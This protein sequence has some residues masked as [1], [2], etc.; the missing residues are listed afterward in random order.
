MVDSI[1]SNHNNGIDEL[2]TGQ[3]HQQQQIERV[4][5][6]SSAAQNSGSTGAILDRADISDEALTRL[7]SEKEVMKYASQASRL[8]EPYDSDKVAHFKALFESGKVGDYLN[9]LSNEALA[10]DVLNSPLG[11][12]LQ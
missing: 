10:D 1:S 4:N 9:S 11:A 3:L 8:E 5:R 6:E 12:I 2:R 7:E